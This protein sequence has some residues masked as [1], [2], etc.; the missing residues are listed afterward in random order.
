MPIHLNLS[1]DTNRIVNTPHRLAIRSA[2]HVRLEA[3]QD[4]HP[5]HRWPQSGGRNATA[6]QAIGSA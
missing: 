2:V 4:R 5:S 6:L 1:S 3:R